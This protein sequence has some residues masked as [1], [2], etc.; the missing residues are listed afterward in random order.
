MA[1]YRNR[2]V[3]NFT[4]S[5][6]NK[7][8]NEPVVTGTVT[9]YITK[10]DNGQVLASNP[11]EYNGNNEWGINFSADEMNANFISIL[12]LHDDAVTLTYNIVTEEPVETVAT[13][14]SFLGTGS[15]ITDGFTYYGSL[16][17]ADNYFSQSL[18]NDAWDDSTVNRRERALSTATKAIDKL[19]FEGVKNDQLQ[20]LQFPRNDDLTIPLDI[21]YACYELAVALLDGVN[22]EQEAQTIGVISESY[23]GVRTT[24]DGSYVNEHI[25]AGIPSIVAWEYLKPYLRDPRLMR[26]SRVN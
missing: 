12:I 26:I 17:G 19:N 5:L 23:S 4:F 24:Y 1:I 7:N 22:V 11:A 18:N 16:V 9:I 6:V 25:R 10:D 14:S 21:E 2:P 8:T 3:T 20:N 13:S 15:S